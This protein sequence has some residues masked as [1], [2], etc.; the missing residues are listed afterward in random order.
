V[1]LAFAV[2]NVVGAVLAWAWRE[3]DLTGRAAAA[4][5]D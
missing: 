2:S 1:W 3:G 4:G 5:D